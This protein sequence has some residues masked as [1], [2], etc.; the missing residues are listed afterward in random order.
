MDLL[1]YLYSFIFASFNIRLEHTP[2]VLRSLVARHPTTYSL[3]RTLLKTYVHVLVNVLV[4]TFFF[5]DKTISCYMDSDTETHSG[6][7]S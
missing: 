1:G 5:L 6:L 4:R 7:F 3:L 2:L